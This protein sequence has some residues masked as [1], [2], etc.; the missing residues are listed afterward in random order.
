MEVRHT[1]FVFVYNPLGN[2][3]LTHILK[4]D[5]G[6]KVIGVFNC[7]STRWGCMGITSGVILDFLDVLSVKSSKPVIQYYY[8]LKGIP[9]YFSRVKN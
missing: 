7:Y 2:E 4:D 3:L 8:K 1:K 9:F 6:T 5:L